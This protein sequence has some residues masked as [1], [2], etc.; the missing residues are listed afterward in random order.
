MHLLVASGLN[1]GYVAAIFWFVLRFLPLPNFWR[2]VLLVP[3]IV[4]ATVMAIAVIACYILE[5]ESLIYHSLTLAANLICVS[6][7][8]MMLWLFFFLSDLC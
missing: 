5:R 2:R 1:V 3:P 8:G 4:R 7:S 6:L